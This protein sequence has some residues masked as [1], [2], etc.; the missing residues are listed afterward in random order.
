MFLPER[1]VAD[2]R[3]RCA[4]CGDVFV[5]SAGEQELLRLR[6]VAAANPT[7]CPSCARSPLTLG[8]RRAA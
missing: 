7:R 5:H 4:Q 8:R 3:L 2:K 1:Q 6:G